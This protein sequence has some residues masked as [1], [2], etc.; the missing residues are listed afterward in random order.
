MVA[1]DGTIF[2]KGGLI[3]GGLSQ[4]NRQRAEQWHAKD[5]DQEK[6]VKQVRGMQPLMGM[7]LWVQELPL[8]H[9]QQLLLGVGLSRFHI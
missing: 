9:L 2:S 7:I 1:A 4:G 3:T 6:T 5:N 8:L